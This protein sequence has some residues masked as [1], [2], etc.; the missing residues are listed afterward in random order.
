[1]GLRERPRSDFDDT[2]PGLI[3]NLLTG[4]FAA[5]QHLVTRISLPIGVSLM[6]VSRINSKC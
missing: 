6:A 1:L 5:E 2:Q 3:N 4:I